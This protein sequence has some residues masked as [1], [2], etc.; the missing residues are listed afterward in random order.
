MYFYL[1]K[2]TGFIPQEDEGTLMATYE[3]AEATSTERSYA[4]LLELVKRIKAIPEVSVV[5]DLQV[6]MHFKAQ[7]N[8]M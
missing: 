3:M 7:I 4:M 8:R 2:P 6:L 5:G 1:Q